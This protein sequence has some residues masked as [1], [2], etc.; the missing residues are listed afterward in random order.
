MVA[1]GQKSSQTDWLFLFLLVLILGFSL[2]LGKSP[3]KFFWHF[4]IT[5]FADWL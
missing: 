2:P 1:E 5:M 3:L 4:L